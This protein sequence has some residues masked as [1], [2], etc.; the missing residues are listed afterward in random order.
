MQEMSTVDVEC[1]DDIHADLELEWDG[2]SFRDEG[3]LPPELMTAMPYE[4]DPR[5]EAMTPF[6]D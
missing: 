2:H 1:G 5:T 4:A 6:D 3:N